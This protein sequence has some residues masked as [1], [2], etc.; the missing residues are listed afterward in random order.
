MTA[1]SEQTGK[2][3]LIIDDDVHL[4]AVLD[5]ALRNEGYQ[6]VLASDG[7]EGL[8]FISDA[9]PDLVLSDVMMPNMDGVEFFYAIRDRLL[10]SDIPII[11]MTALSRKD[12]F[13][14]LE[15]EGAVFLQKP[16]EMERLLD[17]IKVSFL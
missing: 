12:W 5:I 9:Q 2:T 7:E 17:L 13:D 14:E 3:I 4:Q 15:M 6:V 8:R 10:G 11:M 16:F 1:A